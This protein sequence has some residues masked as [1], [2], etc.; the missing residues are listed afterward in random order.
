MGVELIMG[1]AIGCCISV[2]VAMLFYW[3]RLSV[4]KE[5]ER[6]LSNKKTR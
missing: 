4:I 6:M 1:M 3:L 2:S 5:A